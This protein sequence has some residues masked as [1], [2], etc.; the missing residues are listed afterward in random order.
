MSI[1][2]ICNLFA[3]YLQ[4]AHRP[5]LPQKHFTDR[6]GL[7]LVKCFRPSLH[8][9][10]LR[11]H[12]RGA[13]QNYPRPRRRRYVFVTDS[14]SSN[15]LESVAISR[16]I[17]ILKNI[18]GKKKVNLNV[19]AFAEYEL[20]ALRCASSNNEICA[21]ELFYPTAITPTTLW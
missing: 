11:S 19:D 7:L 3:I 21:P 6:C 2:F 5:V 4:S 9:S 17:D 15:V 20:L 8:G 14:S 16:S 1:K 13:R 12:D 18:I 10:T